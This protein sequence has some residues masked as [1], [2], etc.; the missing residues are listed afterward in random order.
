MIPGAD[1]PFLLS[2]IAV[3]LK[4]KLLLDIYQILFPLFEI[5][6]RLVL[7]SPPNLQAYNRDIIAWRLLYYVWQLTFNLM[8]SLQYM[9]IQLVEFRL[10]SWGLCPTLC[11]YYWNIVLCGIYIVKY[12]FHKTCMLECF[13]F[14][15][16]YLQ[17]SLYYVSLHLRRD[18]LSAFYPS[19]HCTWFL[20]VLVKMYNESRLN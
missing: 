2:C 5:C 18:S 3:W 19:G 14:L 11:S 16:L 10:H 4:K 17:I 1:P 6:C 15:I 7:G 9:F 20:F 12:I 8:R 13:C